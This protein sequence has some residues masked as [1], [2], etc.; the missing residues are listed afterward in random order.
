MTI[1]SSGA[2]ATSPAEADLKVW[3]MR[4]PYVYSVNVPAEEFIW[5]IIPPTP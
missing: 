4:T 5:E 3:D 1:V 2:S